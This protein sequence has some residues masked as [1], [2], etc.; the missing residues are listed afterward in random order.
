MSRFVTQEDADIITTVSNDS[1][2]S[3]DILGG[4]GGGGGDDDD[5]KMLMDH[6]LHH[7]VVRRTRQSINF[8][9]G[10]PLVFSGAVAFTYSNT[11]ASS[12][13]K[14]NTGIPMGALVTISVQEKNEPNDNNK[15]GGGKP[16]K[17]GGK[18]NNRRGGGGKPKED[19]IKYPHYILNHNKEQEHEETDGDSENNTAI[20]PSIPSQIIGYG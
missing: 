17:R 4:G 3:V 5:E 14:D 2:E 16:N 7:V 12:I 20:L 6:A 8:R 15:R 11:A 10:S 13:I 18:Y 19:D 1:E 9:N